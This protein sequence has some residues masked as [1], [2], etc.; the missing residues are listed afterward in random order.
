MLKAATWLVGSAVALRSCAHQ[1]HIAKRHVG[2]EG[3]ALPLTVWWLWGTHCVNVVYVCEAV[4][5][6]TRCGSWL[7]NGRSPSL[8]TERA[9][10]NKRTGLEVVLR[11]FWTRWWCSL[12]KIERR[13]FSASILLLIH[14]DLTKKLR[15]FVTI[16]VLRLPITQIWAKKSF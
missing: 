16:K 8:P 7:Q 14:Q 12:P 11:L 1:Q 2:S 10:S 3:R 9:P 6:R 13:P 4:A 5:G 15:I